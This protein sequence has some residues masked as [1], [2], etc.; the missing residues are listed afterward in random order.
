M[1]LADLLHAIQADADAELAATR[2]AADEQAAAIMVAAAAE[3]AALERQLDAEAR[4]DADAET[5]Q[6]LASARLAAAA[7]VRAA[8]E[9]AYQRLRRRLADELAAVRESRGYPTVLGA[10]ID[11]ALAVLPDASCVRV[12]ARDGALAAEHL[13]R[14]AP[15]VALEATMHT[16]GG[17]EAISATGRRVVNTLE[18][19]LADA[20]PQLRLVAARLLAGAER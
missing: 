13:A 2:Q 7:R 6:R 8:R 15:A 16:W 10:L 5:A 9:D 14:E 4:A 18:R 19:R 17:A 1:A 20:E 11:E 3:A 12:D